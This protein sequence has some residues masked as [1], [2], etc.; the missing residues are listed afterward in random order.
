VDAGGNHRKSLSTKQR[1]LQSPPGK[2]D[3]PAD[4]VGRRPPSPDTA[5]KK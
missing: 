3:S 1:R 5:A 4:Q 2:R